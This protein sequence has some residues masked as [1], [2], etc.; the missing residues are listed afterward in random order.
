MQ[1]GRSWTLLA[2][3][4]LGLALLFPVPVLLL[5]A[6]V[7]EPVAAALG[8]LAWGCSSLVF[9]PAVRHFGLGRAWSW[10]LPLAGTL[11]GAMT[12]DSALRGR[13]DWD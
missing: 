13:G 12:L 2:A 10:T 9:R 5:A 7:Y 6:V 3:T 8:A 1:L 4:L 11:Y